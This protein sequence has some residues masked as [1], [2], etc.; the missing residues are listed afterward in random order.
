VRI[1]FLGTGLMGSRMAPRLAAAGY[2]LTV[3]NRSR[4]KGEPLAAVGARVAGSAAQ[5]AL[6]AG[7]A[8][9]MLADEPAVHTVLF[10]SGVTEALELDSLVIDMSS[11]PPARAREHA[12]LLAER[13]IGHV[14]APVSGGT[15]GAAEGTLAIMA[16]GSREAFERARPLLE[17][18]GRPTYVGPAGSGQLAKCVNQLVVAVTIGAVAEGLLLA[19]EGGANPAAVREAI[20]GGFAESRILR[21]HGLRMIERN[22]VPGGYSRLQLKDLNT[23]LD[24]ASEASVELPFLSLARDL[25]ADLV[26]HGEGE[27]DHSAL[28]L[29]L[30]RQAK[31][32]R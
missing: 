15:I 6:G 25:F 13:G 23:I 17:T 11:I 16:G 26:E 32:A 5:A 1:A 21:E 7:V 24:V 28:Y 8:I 19:E 20:L 2:E 10:E 22:F 9:T 30:E 14:D 18:M 4:A 31:S 29:E 3:W 12:R 27:L